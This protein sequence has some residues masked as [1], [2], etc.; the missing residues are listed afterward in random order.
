LTLNRFSAETSKRQVCDLLTEESKN[1]IEVT[2]QEQAQREGTTQTAVDA[3][4]KILSYLIH[5]QNNGYRENTTQAKHDQLFR[6]VRL[7][8]DLND[9]E[10]VKKTIASICKT[11]S[12]KLLL[13]IAYEGFANFNRIAWVRPNYKQNQKLPFIHMNQSL[14]L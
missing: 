7:G 9:S 1:L 5:L 11:E 10:S 6:L 4:G 2:R 13:S 3:K 8:A 14:T 12:Y